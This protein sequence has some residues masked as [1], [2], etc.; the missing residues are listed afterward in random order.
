LSSAGTPERVFHL[1][2]EG[3]VYSIEVATPKND[4]DW[5]DNVILTVAVERCVVEELINAFPLP[6]R[7]MENALARLLERNLLLLD[8][9]DGSVRAS[10][11]KRKE[12]QS[13]SEAWWI[14]KL[15]I[16]QDYVTGMLLPLEQVVQ[17]DV[18]LATEPVAD[19]TQIRGGPP[20]RTPLEMSHAELMFHLRRFHANIDPYAEVRDKHRDRRLTL[21]VRA[22]QHDNRL[23]IRDAV[24][25]PLRAAWARLAG[26]ES[27]EF[28]AAELP[29]PRRWEQMEGRWAQDAQDRL[30]RGAPAADTL[31]PMINVLSMQL[32]VSLSDNALASIRKLARESS[33]SIVV[34]ISSGYGTPSDAVQILMERNIAQRILITPNSPPAAKRQ[35]W[36]NKGIRI[37]T[38]GHLEG[39]DFVLVDGTT[40]ALGSI[41]IPSSTLIEIRTSAPLDGYVAWLASLEISIPPEHRPNPQLAEL[42]ANV[43]A[44]EKEIVDLHGETGMTGPMASD[45][46]AGQEARAR[47]REYLKHR[48]G[49]IEAQLLNESPRPFGWLAAAEVLSIVEQ[50]Q[51]QIRILVRSETSPLAAAAARRGISC[52]KWPDGDVTADCVLLETVVL[53]GFSLADEKSSSPDFLAVADSVF[54]TDLRMA[55]ASF[56]PLERL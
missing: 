6:R 2:A 48:C 49:E 43:R 31:G 13:E 14:D 39:P 25:W 30:L 40:L 11:I 29:L 52:I 17:F 55:T 26:V 42:I 18:N 12:M 3:L 19:R 46:E 35:E 53:W 51:G 10:P 8:V 24:P 56:T 45:D 32:S 1:I 38:T 44:F 50:W 54:A 15:D 7:L 37:V 9:Y 21:A 34:C 16:W 22:S 4:L 41:A 33:S 28:K 36:E 20:R 5:L 27:A 23:A 47:I